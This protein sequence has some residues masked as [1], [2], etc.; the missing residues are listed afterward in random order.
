MQFPETIRLSFENNLILGN[1]PDKITLDMVANRGK[2]MPEFLDVESFGLFDSNTSNYNTYYPDVKA[3]DLQPKEDDFITPTFRALSEVIVHKEWN[4]VDFSANN[5]LKKSM[6]LLKGQSV[7]PDHEATVGNSLGAVMEVAWEE[8]YKAKNG[9]LIPAGINS[10]LKIDGKSNPKIARAILM[11][12]PSIHSTSVTVNFLWEKS[13]PELSQE[14]FFNKLGSPAA[15]GK[16]VRR[17]A[18]LVKKYNEISFVTH[19]ADPFA[20]LI[21]DGTIVN[22]KYANVSYN[23]IKGIPGDLKSHAKHFYFNFKSDVLENAAET[24]IPPKTIDINTSKLKD[25]PMNKEL[26]IMLA[27]FMGVT[28]ANAENPT[29]A[30]LLEI[31]NK[32]TPAI[33]KAQADAAALVTKEAEITRLKEVETKYTALQT[34]SGD[35]VALKAFQDKITGDLRTLVVADYTKLADGK[36]EKAITDMLASADYNTLMALGTSYAQQLNDKY[37]LTC[38]GC[39]GKDINRASA[40]SKDINNPETP[41]EGGL[42]SLIANKSGIGI[43]VALIHGEEEKPAK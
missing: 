17:V 42:Q 19:G 35:A 9:I 21:K 12:P 41:K 37:P 15:D 8:S 30:E 6:S 25:H 2:K 29:D 11:D 33:T 13:H 34:T 39:G 4:P 26:L 24:A 5:V 16:L 36:P 43:G 32:L 27:A 38:K 7:Y 1:T 14:D 22:P 40:Q 3:E 20:Q 18:T 31:K 10:K 28:V 23:S